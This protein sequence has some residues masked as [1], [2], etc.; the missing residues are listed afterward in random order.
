M[1]QSVPDV[2]AVPE[3]A[4]RPEEDDEEEKEEGCFGEETASH[5]CK[6]TK[7]NLTSVMSRHVT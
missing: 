2:G 6:D 5:V 7:H 1:K 4:L 3:V